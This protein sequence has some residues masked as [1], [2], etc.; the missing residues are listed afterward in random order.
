MQGSDR[1][2]A[3]SR[4]TEPFRQEHAEI[5]KHL[6]HIDQMIGSL[7]AAAPVEQR[8][9]MARVVRFF[10]EHILPHA[11]WEERVLYP[12]VDKR[13]GSGENRFTAAM[14]HEHVIVGRWTEELESRAEA[15]TPDAERFSRHADQLLGLILAHFECEEEVLLPI[16]DWTM[17]SEDFQREI[18]SKGHPA[19][20]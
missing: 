17:T 14:R 18:A 1:T 19:G 13:A 10:R 20:H 9:T 5:K 11:E 4:P 2:A 15:A 8:E 3:P 16:L 12:V 7:A 6:G